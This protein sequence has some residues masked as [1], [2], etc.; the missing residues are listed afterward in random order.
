[1]LVRLFFSLLD[2]ATVSGVEMQIEN[3]VILSA[4]KNLLSSAMRAGRQHRVS[5]PIAILR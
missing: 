4:A 5:N 3:A 2:Q 1:L